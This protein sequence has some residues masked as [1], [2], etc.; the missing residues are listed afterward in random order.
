MELEKFAKQL[1]LLIELTQNRRLTIEEVSQRI[2]MNRRS[3]YRYLDALK[4]MGFIIIKEGT[5]YHIDAKSPYLRE[6]TDGLQFNEA[7]AVT[8]SQVLNSIYSNSPQ[9]RDLRAKFAN[10]YDTEV[11]ARHGVDK[12]LAGRISTIYQA[13]REE[14]V[15]ILKDYASHS[16]GVISDRIVEPYVFLHE[17]NEVRCYE[18]SSGENKTFKLNRCQEVALLDLLWAHK[19]K[20]QPFFTDLFHFSGDKKMPVTLIM[21]TLASSLLLEEAPDADRQM[22]VLKDGKV[23]LDTEVCSYKGIGRFVM[24]LIDDIEIVDSPDFV[25]YLQE[26]AEV[27]TKKLGL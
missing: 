25:K 19:D 7:E 21:G 12:L 14:R 13:I 17:N 23:R 1:R 9:I 22:T 11:I 3:I 10:L 8:I 26:K 5:R 16:S 6:L 20:H 4:A 15:A 2:G 24:G 27:L 18:L